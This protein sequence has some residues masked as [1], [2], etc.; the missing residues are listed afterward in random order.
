M[1]WPFL[2]SALL[3]HPN[4]LCNWYL[5]S[6]CCWMLT[7]VILMILP[8]GGEI[9]SIYSCFVK[10][11]PRERQTLGKGCWVMKQSGLQV[12][13]NV[14]SFEHRTPK[15]RSHWL[16]G[17]SLNLVLEA[18]LMAAGALSVGIPTAAN[19]KRWG[20]MCVMLWSL[21]LRAGRHSLLP[22][23]FSCPLPSGWSYMSCQQAFEEAEKFSKYSDNGVVRPEHSCGLFCTLVV[24][25]FVVAHPL[26][27]VP[28]DHG[29][30]GPGLPQ[31]LLLSEQ[32][33]NLAW[34][35]GSCWRLAESTDIPTAAGR[36]SLSLE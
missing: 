5:V 12:L 16:K 8:H 32:W 30:S 21:W 7:V 33:M 23:F 4:A 3:L 25:G 36:G 27:S 11:G 6:E 24:T 18:G 15:E 22:A 10:Q 17:I 19:Q 28:A 14:S 9:P 29:N 35:T 2:S 20:V 34:G 31:C 13:K 1:L 26:L